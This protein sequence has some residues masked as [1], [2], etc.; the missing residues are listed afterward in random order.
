[1][2]RTHYTTAPDNRVLFA[3]TNDGTTRVQF[4]TGDNGYGTSYKF[5]GEVSRSLGRGQFDMTY[6]DLEDSL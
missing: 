4:G 5:Y 3:P 1:M 6:L 2:E